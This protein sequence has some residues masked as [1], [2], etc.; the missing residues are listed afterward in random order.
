MASAGAVGA[1]LPD[2]PAGLH[3]EVRPQHQEPQR[4][5]GGAA[6]P[7]PPPGEQGLPAQELQQVSPD[8]TAHTHTHHFNKDDGIR[9]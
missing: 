7:R 8:A 1:Q 4:A 2:Q 9:A 3:P 5:A 6:A